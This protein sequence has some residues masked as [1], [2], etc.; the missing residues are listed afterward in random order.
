MLEDLVATA[1]RD[2]FEKANAL[3]DQRLGKLMPGG[4]GLPPGLF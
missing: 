3:R 4:M 2:A 1:I